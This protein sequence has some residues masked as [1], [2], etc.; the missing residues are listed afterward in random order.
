MDHVEW[1][2]PSSQKWLESAAHQQNTSGVVSTFLGTLFESIAIVVKQTTR[3][4][5][6]CTAWQTREDQLQ[7]GPFVMLS[8]GLSQGAWFVR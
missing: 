6:E 2:V 8:T 3:Q 1:C 5:R 4:S 7:P